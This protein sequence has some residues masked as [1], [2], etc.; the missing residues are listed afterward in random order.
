MLY[1][2]IGSDILVNISSAIGL[3]P[4]RHQAITNIN[5]D[6]LSID[7]KA[8]KFSEIWFNNTFFGRKCI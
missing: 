3:S 8:T 6:L 2:Q 4:I 7:S 5:V 1:M